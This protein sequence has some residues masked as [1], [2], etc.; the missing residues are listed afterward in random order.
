M[1]IISVE[2]VPITVPYKVG[3]YHSWG[4]R[5]AGDYIILK[6]KTDSGLIGLGM[7]LRKAIQRSC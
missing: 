4:G 2:V 3:F 7:R 6:M 1:R 5:T